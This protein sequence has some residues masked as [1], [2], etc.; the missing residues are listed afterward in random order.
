MRLHLTLCAILTLTLTKYSDSTTIK[1]IQRVCE[2][3]NQSEIPN[4]QEQMQNNLEYGN[5]MRDWW[6]RD[7]LHRIADGEYNLS[8]S[9]AIVFVNVVR[10]LAK[11]NKN[12]IRYTKTNECILKLASMNRTRRSTKTPMNSVTFLRQMAIDLANNAFPQLKSYTEN[13]FENVTN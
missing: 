9:E 6:E 5:T 2:Q 10:K 1:E 3:V 12:C 4:T 8:S 7:F 13:L 11:V